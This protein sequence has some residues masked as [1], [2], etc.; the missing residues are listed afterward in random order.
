MKQSFL[1]FRCVLP[2]MHNLSR[3]KVYWFAVFCIPCSNSWPGGLRDKPWKSK[4]YTF[5]TKTPFLFGTWGVAQPVTRNFKH[6]NIP[7]FANGSRVQLLDGEMFRSIEISEVLKLE[8][9]RGIVGPDSTMKRIFLVFLC[10][11]PVLHRL[12]GLKA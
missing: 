4:T 7:F 1:A 3:L 8:K 5:L 11:L 12:S 9:N 10:V 6:Y 2:P